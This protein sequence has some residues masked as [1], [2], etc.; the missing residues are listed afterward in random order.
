MHRLPPRIVP[1]ASPS[2]STH[3]PGLAMSSR[4]V[5][6]EE[7]LIVAPFRRRRD[8]DG[9]FA[10]EA[11]E[12]AFLGVLEISSSFRTSSSEGRNR[13]RDRTAK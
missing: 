4:L 10:E 1:E 2:F 6:V 12:E 13:S 9:F 5:L 3:Q 11:G 8:A 7:P